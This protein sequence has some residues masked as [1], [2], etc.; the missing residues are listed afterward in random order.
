[1]G[2]WKVEVG[3]RKSAGAQFSNFRLPISHFQSS[4]LN[5]AQ[6]VLTFDPNLKTAKQKQMDHGDAK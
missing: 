4:I 2:R 5:N 3:S 1:M 6:I